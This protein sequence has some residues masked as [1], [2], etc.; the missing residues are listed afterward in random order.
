[1]GNAHPTKVTLYVC[2]YIISGLL[3]RSIQCTYIGFTKI[4]IC[5]KITS[6]FQCLPRTAMNKKSILLN[7]IITLVFS[8]GFN[9]LLK[10]VVF[11]NKI[12]IYTSLDKSLYIQYKNICS[13]KNKKPGI[14]SFRDRGTGGTLTYL[15]C[16]LHNDTDSGEYKFTESEG[17][18]RCFGQMVQINSPEKRVTT[19][20]IKGAVSGYQCSRIGEEIEFKMNKESRLLE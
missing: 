6:E 8:L 10:I 7:F 17:K 19:W 9:Y 2:F 11:R 1:M 20:K 12:K 18:E 15:D 14:Y 16:S 13:S 3:I 4:I 5:A